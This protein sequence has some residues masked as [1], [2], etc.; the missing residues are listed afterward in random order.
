MDRQSLIERLQK[1][2]D[3]EERQRNTSD[4]S[5]V[6]YKGDTN[7][8]YVKEQKLFNM[9]NDEPDTLHVMSEEEIFERLY[10]ERQ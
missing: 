5:D 3:G 2:F 9:Q 1:A 7:T 6:E 4:I 10:K 8:L